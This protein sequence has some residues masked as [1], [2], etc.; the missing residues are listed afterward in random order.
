VFRLGGLRESI[1]PSSLREL[2]AKKSA[3]KHKVLIDEQKALTTQ[4]ERLKTQ[5]A[6]YF[7]V[8]LNILE[9]ASR[10]KEI[11]SKRTST[12][13]RM[14]LK[15][16]F[17]HISLKD[18]KVEYELKTP[19]RK[20]YEKLTLDENTFEPKKAFTNAVKASSGSKITSMLRG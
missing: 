14:L 6:E 12:E 20:L 4:L 11:Y 1:K 9:L 13:K 5:E 15:H 2:K 8:G 18:G 19:V 7:E 10:A 16:L 17:K 3:G